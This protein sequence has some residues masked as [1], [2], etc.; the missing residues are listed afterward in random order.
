MKIQ[1]ALDR[2]NI[3]SA[4]KIV[5]KVYDYI[6]IIEVGTSLIKDY[7]ISSVGKMRKQF[8]DKLI[9]ADLKTM[10]EGEYEFKTAY[11]AGADIATV[12]GVTPLNTISLCYDVAQKYKKS[13]MIDLMETNE[14]RITNL[15]KFKEAIFCIHIA[16]DE[17]EKDFESYFQKMKLYI[18]EL[19]H[20]AIAG[21]IN[22][23]LLNKLNK[24][25]II[26]PEIVIIGSAITKA[27]DMQKA[28]KEFYSLMQNIK[29]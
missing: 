26:K 14:S 28:A 15:K 21:G 29:K 5:E 10:D 13:I 8:P 17:I 25:R 12:M 16:K 4:I 9:L 23:E 22:I 19:P 24:T 18:S 20:L 1:L 6:D 2:I 11:S 3:E 27:F 7:G